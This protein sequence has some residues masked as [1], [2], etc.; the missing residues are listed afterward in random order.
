MVNLVSPGGS[1][2]RYGASAAHQMPVLIECGSASSFELSP[3]FANLSIRG[4][5][6]HIQDVENELR[7]AMTDMAI[8]NNRTSQREGRRNDFLVDFSFFSR[9]QIS[10]KI[11]WGK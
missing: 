6:E 8:D 2:T 1:I 5:Q 11:G 7:E 4:S 9:P 3:R 10:W